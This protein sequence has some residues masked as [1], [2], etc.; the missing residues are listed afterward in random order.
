LLWGVITFSILICF[1]DFWCP[2]YSNGRDSS[3]VLTQGTIEPSPWIRPA[4]N[5][6][7]FSHWLVYPSQIS[8]IYS[9]KKNPFFVRKNQC[10]SVIIRFVC[11][12][13]SIICYHPKQALASIGEKFVQN[14]EN[15]RTTPKLKS[16]MKCGKNFPNNLV[17]SKLWLLFIGSA[18]Q[19]TN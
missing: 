4:L 15:W 17:F 6:E 13:F 14:C 11:V 3:F 7:V 10:S 12:W 19:G 1:Y 8:Q 2:R 9:Q 5:A 16:R 18:L